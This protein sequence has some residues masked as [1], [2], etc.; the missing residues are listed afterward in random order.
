MN[1]IG[2]VVR[3]R[4]VVSGREGGILLERLL[5]SATTLLLGVEHLVQRQR[6][7]WSQRVH[8]LLVLVHLRPVLEG[9]DRQHDLPCCWSRRARVGLGLENNK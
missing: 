5:C 6:R 4:I 7:L 1:E 2:S 9:P 3:T 8:E